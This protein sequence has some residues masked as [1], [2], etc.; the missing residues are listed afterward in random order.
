VS[1]ARPRTYER[2]AVA[3]RERA[4]ALG[5]RQ[6]GHRRRAGAPA[7]PTRAPDS[8]G[9]G[10]GRAIDRLLGNAASPV[11][12]TVRLVS[13]GA[14]PP[15]RPAVYRRRS[16]AVRL[17]PLPAGCCDFRNC[18]CSVITRIPVQLIFLTILYTRRDFSEQ[19]FCDCISGV[20]LCSR[21][22]IYL[23]K[24]GSHICAKVAIY[25]DAFCAMTDYCVTH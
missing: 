15:C 4:A 6:E 25:K 8:G 24:S 7:A 21:C 23:C 22:D 13:C 20:Y 19:S 18:Y 12:A 14:R 11:S 1:L 2:L 9:E 16:V 3:A 5:R 10:R 17:P